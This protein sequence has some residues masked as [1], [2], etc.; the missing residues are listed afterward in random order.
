MTDN[1]DY[2][3]FELF[4][5]AMTCPRCHQFHE[6]CDCAARCR[7]P[8]ADVRA[9]IADNSMTCALCQLPIFPASDDLFGS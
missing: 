5:P 2:L 3:P 8:L 4:D 6:Y 7:C 1:P 9:S